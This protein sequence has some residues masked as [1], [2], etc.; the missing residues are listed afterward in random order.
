MAKHFISKSCKTAKKMILKNKIAPQNIEKTCQQELP[1][2]FAFVL[3]WQRQLCTP[4]TYKL[5][6]VRNCVIFHSH[7]S[8]DTI[9]CS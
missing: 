1:P 5:L 4:S 8:H 7:L 2:Y 6:Q 9:T 3:A